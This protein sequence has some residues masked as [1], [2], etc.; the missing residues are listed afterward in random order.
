MLEVLKERG[1]GGVSR[2]NEEDRK[3]EAFTPCP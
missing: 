2:E 3:E 1:E